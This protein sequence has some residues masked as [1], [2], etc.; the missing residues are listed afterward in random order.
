MTA[1]FTLIF[2]LLILLTG[3]DDGPTPTPPEPDLGPDMAQKDQGPTSECTFDEE[4]ADDAWCSVDERFL[5]TCRTGC[6][7]APDNCD[8][9]AR[10]LCNGESR[11]C[12]LL[13]CESDAHC[14]G[15]AYCGA[16]GDCHAGCRTAPDNC[17]P[18]DGVNHTCV[19]DTRL[20][21][22]LYACC[23]DT[24]RCSTVR[25]TQC[26]GQVFVG[27]ASCQPNPCTDPCEAD[28]DCPDDS[29]C[30]LERSRCRLGCRLDQR[31]ACPAHTACDPELRQCLP[32]LC[33]ADA[34]CPAWQFCR[35][36]TC[37][38]GC[39]EGE[40]GDGQWCDPT[41]RLCRA[42]CDPA[43]H[44]GCFMGE[45]CGEDRRC[46]AGCADD[47][48]ELDGG[49]DVPGLAN[50]LATQLE[51]TER[52]AHSGDRVAC[53]DDPD[54][55]RFELREDERLQIEFEHDPGLGQ[56]QLQLT[57]PGGLDRT[58][59]PLT[60][61]QTIRLPEA[62][63][64]GQGAPAGPY[65][66]RVSSL[67]SPE[68]MG[69]QLNFSARNAANGCFGDAVDPRDDTVAGAQRAGL[70]DLPRFTDSF[71]R[72][73]CAGDT[74]FVCFNMSLSDG[75]DAVVVAPPGCALTPEL[76][77]EALSERPAAF[78][79][80]AGEPTPE[81]TA[82]RFYG[83]PQQRTFSAQSWCL[84]VRGADA[85]ASCEGYSIDLTFLRSG[86]AC[87]DAVE[88]NDGPAT[89]SPLDGDGPLA[90]IEGRLT[91]GQDRLLDLNTRICE[92]DHDVFSLRADAGDALR[93][94]LV[95][96]PVDDLRGQLS[97]RFLDADGAPRGDTGGINEAADGE[98]RALTVAGGDG[99]YFVEVSGEGASTGT[100]RLYVRRDPG[101]GVCDGDLHETAAVRSDT[102]ETAQDL[103]EIEGPERRG[104]NNAA[105]CSPDA[106]TTDVDWYELPVAQDRTRICV[107]AAFRHQEGNLDVD[108]F[109]AGEERAV[110]CAQGCQA[111]DTCV[112][113]LCRQPLATGNS[114]TDNEI[115]PLSANE[116]R[117]GDYL[118]RVQGAGNVSNG[119]DLSATLA[120]PSDG[121]CPPDYRERTRAND[122]PRAATPLGSGRVGIC[123]AWLCHGERNTGDWYAI[124][125]P[126]GSDRTVHINYNPRED[127][128]LLLGAHDA[129][130][131]AR[132]VAS[133][134]LQTSAQC[135]NIR[136]GAED[137]QVL[138]QVSADSVVDDG[139][140]RVD[141]TLQVVP[142]DLSRFIRGQC[143]RLNG[144]LYFNVG[145]PQLALP[146]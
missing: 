12:E 105:I 101:D 102:A 74:D 103:R 18:R 50:A 35:V 133:L 142:T 44:D 109:W 104:V 43:T 17:R 25:P 68:A 16:D 78:T 117:A 146:E 95:A 40:C 138:V 116:V 111:Q 82:W 62:L 110:P 48:G 39:R 58:W 24:Q 122:D 132:G 127:G 135:I 85:D 67:D 136:G 83:E 30:D 66:V 145:W 140:R 11:R 89:A 53:P 46:A 139:D 93:A 34:H 121:V 77:P 80:E 31:A 69:Y 23:D 115:V 98:D 20:C 33:D 79:L 143:D 99:Q 76:V 59:T 54:L 106:A 131:A 45:R 1:R 129:A 141:Y 108:L 8:A 126:A 47:L 2:G 21:A 42:D 119:Y 113:G 144:N 22:P 57:G 52:V 137:S 81:G 13:D 10:I 19:E 128:V 124:D 51:G 107:N 55:Y 71:Q 96:S 88:P 120:P 27:L 36:D 123:D 61:K 60:P 130:D 118:V 4:C 90:D 56:L 114:R 32:T 65:L 134:Q 84:R 87:G 125:V 5:G 70:A 86:D 7:T 3:C 38:D 28:V 14:A 26:S 94:W 37:L 9:E 15:D 64:A 29:V 41:G 75:L 63:A 97:V 112:L 73:L 49:D 91:A 100:Y 92:G 6:R 72:D